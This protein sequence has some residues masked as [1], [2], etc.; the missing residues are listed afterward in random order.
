MLGVRVGL[1]EGRCRRGWE[2]MRLNSPPARSEIFHVVN[3]PCLASL[4]ATG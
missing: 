4:C 1:P 2:N 3:R